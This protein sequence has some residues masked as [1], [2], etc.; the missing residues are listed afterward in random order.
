MKAET[1]AKRRV[2]LSICG[3]G[4][5][6]ESEVESLPP[7]VLAPVA[8]EVQSTQ[9]TQEDVPESTDIPAD[10]RVIIKVEAGTSSSKGR[11]HFHKP[12]EGQESLL[13]WQ[14]WVV[15]IATELVQTR[16]PVMVQTKTSAA[17][18]VRVE[19]LKR[20]K[21]EGPPPELDDIPF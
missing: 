16:E 14:Q 19:A 8:L 17:G 5:L 21:P 2:T 15:D 7:E 1:K 12:V 20:L 4:M 3:L 9:F 13:T 6:D 10:A 18:N 11:I